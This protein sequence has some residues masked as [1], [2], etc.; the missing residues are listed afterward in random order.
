M[1][2]IEEH[3]EPQHDSVSERFL[4]PKKL[5]LPL[6][7]HTGKPSQSC[8]DKGDIVE[9]GQVI[10]TDTALVSA[11][12]H[13]PL[14]GKIL[15]IDNWFH[16]V[17][18]RSPCIVMECEQEE[19]KYSLLDNVDA[20]S[21]DEL[22][23]IVKDNGVVGMGGAAFPTHVK[24]MPPKSIETLIING[25]ECEPY[26][27]IDNR[28][29]IENLD[30]IFKGIEII[31][32]IITPKKVIFGIENNKP[33]A[34]EKIKSFS[35]DKFKVPQFELKVL[36]TAYPQGGEKQLIHA[37]TGKKVAGG[38][39]PFDAG[40]LVFNV[41][42]IFA[43]YQAVYFNKPLVERLV[44][45]AG[46]ALFTPKNIW[47]KVG[48][49]LAQLFENKILEFKYEP[50]K[51]ICG[52]P[53]MGIS[54][55]NLDYPILK[56]SGG[57]LFLKDHVAE[58]EEKACIRC[59]RCVDACPMNL[60]PLEYA[61]R[62]KVEEYDNLENYNIKDCIECGCCTYTCPAKIPLIQYIKIGKKYLPN[63]LN[64]N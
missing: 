43:V 6:A 2:K 10:A 26:L 52:G 22:I 40:C 17:L 14:K 19:K 31:C 24:L 25:C 37:V 11:K 38:K 7:Q 34:I 51:I 63:S 55:D 33:Q 30:E 56:G 42:T 1:I 54:L 28:L 5:Y 9:E 20:L 39:L 23:E 8:V 15:K 45:F 36:E 12:L 47:V 50:K 13:A 64:N 59:A 48:T 3:K 41:G 46:D 4:N 57:F 60:L 35:V 53:M 18:K 62:V 58:L 61:K 16:P 27:A 49:T 29:M 32:K 44:S 21:K